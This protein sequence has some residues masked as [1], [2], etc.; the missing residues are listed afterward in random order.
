MVESHVGYKQFL[1]DKSQVQ[2]DVGLDIQPSDLSAKLYPFQQHLTSWA[3]RKGRA[4]IF[5]DCG[6][7]KTFMQL[8]WAR[9]VTGP[10][11]IYAPLA[12]AQQT[13]YE[14]HKLDMEVQYCRDQSDV[15]DGVNITNYEMLDHFD[16]EYFSGVV[17]DESSILKST[18]GKTRQK[19][20]DQYQTVPYR[21]CC[22]ATPA[23]NDIAE[24]A[25][26]AEF[27]GIMT[28]AQMLATYFVHDDDGWRLKGHGRDAFYRWL[29]SWG[30]MLRNPS[31]IGFD[32]ED[33]ILP[34]LNVE[35]VWVDADTQAFAEASGQLF[36]TGL[37][38]IE[39]RLKARKQTIGRRV[40]TLSAILNAS[41]EQ[42]VV[43]CGLND[44]GRELAK[45]VPDA[46]LVEGA[47]SLGDKIQR[48]GQ[49]MDQSKR[50]LI[51]K[52]SIA[53]FGMNF[54]HCHNMAFLGLS[55][56]YE[57]YYQAIRRCWRYGQQEPVNVKII[58]ADIERPI[59]DNV[60]GK[61][62]V[63]EDTTANV[64]KHGAEF[65]RQELGINQNGHRESAPEDSKGDGWDMRLGDCVERLAEM[66]AESIDFSVFSPPFLSL[67]S[68]SDSNRDMGNSRSDAEFLEHFSYFTDQI[69][70]VMRPGRMVAVHVAQV[71]AKLVNDGYIGIKDFRGMVI[72]KFMDSGFVYYGDVTVDKNPQAQA[73]RTHSKAL[74][75]KQLKKDSSWLRPG[76]ADYVLL[77]R[78][79]GENEVPIHPNISNEEWITWAHPVWYDIRESD[80]L[81][82][83]EARSDADEKHIAP[84]QLGVIERCIR[85][86]S[87]QDDL[88]LSPFAGIGSEGYEAIKNNRRFIGIELKPEYYQVAI[89]NLN[90]AL[91]SKSQMQMLS[92][93][94]L[95]A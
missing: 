58:I 10:V 90:R 25:N 7:G 78:N 79:Q 76:L 61:E 74:L 3:L 42:W 89:R 62:E 32:G 21:L 29:A 54:Q 28:R 45:A 73:I 15:I 34:A 59:L 1:E 4:A 17:L 9:H 72:Q 20:I 53:G 84:L 37:S 27:L 66:P 71:A 40:D 30:I 48:I 35:P 14:A 44:E 18:D 43:W 5:A 80:T 75:F 51:S 85:L 38:G 60:I 63:H 82:T 68:Y 56:S 24:L 67:Y 55:D 92:T 49:F 65:A 13:K 77:F 2:P 6:L 86:W 64:V 70:R 88:V 23:P 22:T 47:D 16:P 52:V 33:F 26:H 83:L 50:I 95:F 8:E 94:E 87:N 12:V 19:L 57:Q 41:D 31:D 91:A 36:V 11:L 81:N 39:G 93:G 69:Q 46:V